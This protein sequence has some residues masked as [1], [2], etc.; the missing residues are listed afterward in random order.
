MT[1]NISIKLAPDIVYVS[2]LVNNK[3]YS[4]TLSSTDDVHSSWAAVV[5][6]VTPDIYHCD[7]TAI[8]SSGVS[9]NVK[10]TLYYGLNL[11]TDRTQSDVDLIKTL[12]ESGFANM[13]PEEVEYYIANLKGA[14]NASDLNRVEAAV[15]Y[16]AERL[17][18]AGYYYDLS[19]KN[20]WQPAELIPIEE[21]RRYIKNIK[22]I[23]DTF[24]VPKEMPEAPADMNNF[25]FEEANAIERILEIVDGIITD[26]E[27]TFYYSGEIE[28]GEVN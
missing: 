22:I 7:I 9:A 3:E 13:T 8:N 16:I 21:T 11:I 26:I 14:Y 5:D 25:N 19:I 20:T 12:N 27:K 10:T 15:M 1:Q 23:R 17:H 28:A 6:R 4:F 24:S 18:I 2:G